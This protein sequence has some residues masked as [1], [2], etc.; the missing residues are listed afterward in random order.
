MEKQTLGYGH[1]QPQVRA[2]IIAKRA[3]KQGRT[4]IH[5]ELGH[6]MVLTPTNNGPTS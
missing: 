6:R 1:R 3:D 5:Q 2:T 4:H